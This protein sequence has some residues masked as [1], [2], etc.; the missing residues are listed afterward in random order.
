MTSG[1]SPVWRLRVPSAL[2][3]LLAAALPSPALANDGFYQGGGSS[4]RPID[5]A[6]MRV[7]EERL[8]ITPLRE[9]R[10][11]GVRFQGYLLDEKKLPPAAR[12]LPPTPDEFAEIDE[13]RPCGPLDEQ[14]GQELRVFWQVRAEYL[15]EALSDQE[16]VLLGF[17]VPTWD[18]A[19]F[20]P[21]PG[22]GGEIF[23]EWD[24]VP[25]PSVAAF[26]TYID[27]GEVMGPRLSW[28]ELSGEEGTAAQKTLGYVWQASFRQGRQYVLRTE[29][30]FGLSASAGFYAG[31]EYR[32][33]E[34]PPWFL[35]PDNL[36]EHI[37][38]GPH[39]SKDAL[40]LVYYL[41]PLRAWRA[42]P[43]ERIVIR[44]DRPEQLPLSYLVP[45]EPK[46]F[47]VDAAGVLYEYRDQYPCTELELALPPWFGSRH[48]GNAGDWP[49]LRTEED[50]RRWRATLGNARIT[51]GLAGAPG[52]GIADGVV[53]PDCV[54]H[55]A[56]GAGR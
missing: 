9:P 36:P 18:A 30:S 1:R 51:C 3:A 15:V 29:Y 45:I 28:L 8:V 56:P 42:R 13:E 7:I 6:Q 46:P 49:L 10:C 38:K 22:P 34:E 16:Q 54:E 19:F 33:G 31:R 37:G 5:N 23:T 20:Y 41:S 27:D 53:I 35:A 14:H 44:L 24:N 25:A 47:C 39:R 43:P 48:W 55:C 4:L 11:H 50:L 12:L 52:S 2:V 26:H 17:P 21:V 32:Q 40:R